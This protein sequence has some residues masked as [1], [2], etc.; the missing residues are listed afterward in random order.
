MKVEKELDS[1]L[2]MF[3]LAVYHSK[4]KAYELMVSTN[5]TQMAVQ[6]QLV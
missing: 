1:S 3:S 4:Q 2:A 6:P 5:F